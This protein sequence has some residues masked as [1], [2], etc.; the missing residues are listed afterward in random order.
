[1][2]GPSIGQ[3]FLLISGGLGIDNRFF[4]CQQFII[5][6]G[7]EK[8]RRSCLFPE[9]A[10]IERKR[11]RRDAEKGIHSAPA[12]RPPVTLLRMRCVRWLPESRERE[13]YDAE[14]ASKQKAE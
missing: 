3:H 12:S 13:A 14:R 8:W 10:V 11:P 9:N 4:S 5:S 7:L 6:G 2:S 1:M